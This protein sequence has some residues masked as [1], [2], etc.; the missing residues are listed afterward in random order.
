MTGYGASRPGPEVANYVVKIILRLLSEAS[1]ELP[2][3]R[4][5]AIAIRMTNQTHMFGYTIAFAA[6]SELLLSDA[7]FIHNDQTMNGRSLM[8][9]RSS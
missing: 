3:V 6:T 9:I 8:A 2:V 4:H 7:S 1:A 5:V